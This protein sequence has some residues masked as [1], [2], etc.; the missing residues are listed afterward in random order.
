MH[1]QLLIQ[2]A[3]LSP[4]ISAIDAV[5]VL[6]EHITGGIEVLPT[7]SDYKGV[8]LS[9]QFHTPLWR[10]AGRIT[11]PCVVWLTCSRDGSREIVA[12]LTRVV[13]ALV[14]DL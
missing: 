14:R 1:T 12:C 3:G 5:P 2:L 10:T 13:T 4:S 6:T 9:H 8:V 11:S 7:G